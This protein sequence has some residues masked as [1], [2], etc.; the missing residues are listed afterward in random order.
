MLRD[1]AAVIAR[2]TRAHE[3]RRAAAGPLVSELRTALPEVVK[4]LRSEFSVHRVFLFGSFTQGTPTPHSDVDLAVEG[5]P[6]RD[7]FRAMAYLTNALGRIV[8]LVR[9]EDLDARRRRRLV[10]EAVPV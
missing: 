7:H 3:E 2:V 8:D 9:L 4:T 10:E 1:R 6:A 5:L